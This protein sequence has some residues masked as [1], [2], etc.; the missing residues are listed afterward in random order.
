M[1][2]ALEKPNR[3]MKPRENDLKLAVER[4]GGRELT[5]RERKA[6]Q[7]FCAGLSLRCV[8]ETIGVSSGT[9]QKWKRNPAF[10][11]ALAEAMD[12]EGEIHNFELRQ[13]FGKALK[14]V[15]DLLDDKNPHI[16]VQAARLA[17]EAHSSILRMAEEREMI[18]ALEGRMDALAA[19]AA[20]GAHL[21]NEASAEALPPFEEEAD[22]I[23]DVRYTEESD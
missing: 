1:V 14:R 5:P 9:V 16:R 13:L 10:R 8:A 17:L 3:G 2:V 19:N 21:L 12:L 18:E 15:D 6:V 4:E 7:L 11:Q 22:D 23:V 20:H